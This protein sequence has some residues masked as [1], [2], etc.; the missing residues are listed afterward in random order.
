[1]KVYGVLQICKSELGTNKLRIFELLDRQMNLQEIEKVLNFFKI[2]D[3]HF[4]IT[5]A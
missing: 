3:Y 2:D 4:E 1:M 5:D